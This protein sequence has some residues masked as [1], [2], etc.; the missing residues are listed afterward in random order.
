[1]NSEF[2]II[3]TPVEPLDPSAEFVG[4]DATVGDFWRWA[5]SDLRMN[6]NRGALAEFMVAVAVG[7]TPELSNGWNSFDVL[8]PDGTRIEVKSSGYLQSWPQK[9]L[10]VPNFSRLFSVPWDNELGVMGTEAS[11]NADVFVFALQTQT[12]PDEYDPLDV[13]QWDFWVAHADRVRDSKLRSVGLGWVR[14][15]ATGPVAFGEIKTTIDEALR[16]AK[17]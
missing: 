11:V 1:M 9:R 4:I 13:S 16:N 7:S 17:K 6:T 10:S 8:A 5:F 3:P 2:S 14:K 15:H 12:V